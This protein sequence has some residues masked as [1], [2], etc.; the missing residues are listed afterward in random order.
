MSVSEGDDIVEKH[1]FIVSNADLVIV[2]KIDMEK[3]WM[4]MRIR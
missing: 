1:S 3:Q 2:N 4:R